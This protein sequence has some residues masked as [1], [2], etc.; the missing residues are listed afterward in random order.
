VLSGRHD[1]QHAALIH[2]PSRD[3][4]ENPAVRPGAFTATCALSAQ[5]PGRSC[6]R[7]IFASEDVV[8]VAGAAARSLQFFYFDAGG[9]HRS[10][11]TALR[12]VIAE[13]KALLAF[14]KVC[15]E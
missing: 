6:D 9:G 14:A 10:A 4:T 2:R 15:P 5:S 8:R 7:A 11:A 13:H 1:L 3:G 12:Q